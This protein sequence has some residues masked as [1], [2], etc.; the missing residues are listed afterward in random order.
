[1]AAMPCWRRWPTRGGGLD[2]LLALPE[3]AA[4][5]GEAAAAAPLPRPPVET[6]ARK[7]LEMLLPADTVHQGFVARARPLPDLDL[8]SLLEAIA[9][10]EETLLVVL[11]QASDPR[12][13]G[14]VLR[15]S[16]AFAAASVLVQDRHAPEETGALAKAASGALEAV[17]LI[18]CVN[19]ARAMRTLKDH[20]FHCVGL[21]GEATLDLAQARLTGRL[22]L[23][24]GAEGS[25]LRRLVRETCDE[26]A[27]I[28]I[29]P[30][31]DSLN[32][33]AA[34][35]VALYECRRGGARPPHHPAAAR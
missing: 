24:L 6:L 2:R 5:L 29:A 3:T 13:V 26:L 32:L 27:R 25:G 12:N 15:S 7:A 16:Q 19:L 30:G 10:N 20:D 4:V 9:A 31:A 21:A 28:P 18:R 34:A 14:A 33:S 22:A 8:E 35:A 11:D 1:M 17:P 23:I